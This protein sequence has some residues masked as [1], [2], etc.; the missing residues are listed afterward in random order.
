M[1]CP[2]CTQNTARLVHEIGR[3]DSLARQDGVSGAAYISGISCLCGYWIDADVVP[4]MSVVPATPA[5]PKREYSTAEKTSVFYIVVKFFDSIAD[6][7]EKGISWLVIARLLTQAGHR[8]QEKTL[9]KHFLL[10][11]GKR[12]GDEKT[13]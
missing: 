6:Q 4:V 2:K 7:R 5:E 3:S 9:Q 11:Q 13:S 1:I 10:E 12:C 8:C